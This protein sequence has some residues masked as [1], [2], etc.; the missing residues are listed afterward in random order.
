[1]RLIGVTTLASACLF[2][3]L[4]SPC[5]GDV[6][7]LGVTNA[8]TIPNGAR[9]NPMETFMVTY[10]F[11]VGNTLMS[12]T[13]SFTITI[14]PADVANPTAKA[15]A[16]AAKIN[17]TTPAPANLT[18]TDNG[19]GTVMFATNGNPPQVI[20]NITLTQKAGVNANGN[21]FQLGEMDATN[22]GN[23]L[24]NRYVAAL[25]FQGN[26]VGGGTAVVDLTGPGGTSSDIVVNTTFGESGSA[27]AQAVAIA[28]GSATS[29]T[30]VADGATVSILGLSNANTF[31]ASLTDG[32][33]TSF[34]ESLSA[35]PEPSPL[36][37]GSIT[38]LG[39][40]ASAVR[41]AA[42]RVRRTAR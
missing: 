38:A 37:L 28:I 10:Q 29:F 40:L 22:P 16:I 6:V 5:L 19:A 14:A 25:N 17:A 36:M 41:K 8:G 3:C 35:V 13:E 15:A 11:A 32:G 7:S 24:T 21:G 20:T 9:T 2:A 4:P 23:L 33:F 26:G 12:R 34:T 39:L 42:N 1:M 30:A 31:A 18:V 27:L